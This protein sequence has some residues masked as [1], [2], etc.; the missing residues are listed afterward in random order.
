MPHYSMAVSVKH[1][2]KV[3]KL[4]LGPDEQCLKKRLS[5]LRRAQTGKT[6]RKLEPFLKISS[7]M[8]AFFA[9]SKSAARSVCNTLVLRLPIQTGCFCLFVAINQTKNLGSTC[10]SATPRILARGSLL[11]GA[12]ICHYVG[13]AVVWPIGWT[14]ENIRD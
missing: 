6:C 5:F 1:K 9:R 14:S 3:E 2:L 13:I 11:P 8:S 12:K 4:A 10:S 7:C